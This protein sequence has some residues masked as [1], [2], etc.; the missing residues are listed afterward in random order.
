MPAFLNGSVSP[1]AYERWLGR[2]AMAHV[3]RDRRRG[4]AAATRALYKAAIQNNRGQST[5]FANIRT[6]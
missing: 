6:R 5:V 2:K 1:E 4:N 3:K